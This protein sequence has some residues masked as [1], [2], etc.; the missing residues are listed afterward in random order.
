M[1]LSVEAI[2]RC[3]ARQI[4]RMGSVWGAD[5]LHRKQDENG[6]GKSF[7]SLE[8]HRWKIQVNIGPNQ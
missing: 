8:L 1:Y 5:T 4:E 6:V 7:G 2:L 3:D